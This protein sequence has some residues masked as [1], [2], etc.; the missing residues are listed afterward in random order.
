M[1]EIVLHY[2]LLHFTVI[3]CEYPPFKANAEGDAFMRKH[4]SSF[5]DI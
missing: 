1:Q 2:C 4:I 3:T 5:V